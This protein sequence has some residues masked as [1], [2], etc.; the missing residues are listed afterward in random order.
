MLLP[1]GRSIK[2]TYFLNFLRKGQEFVAF[3]RRK[4]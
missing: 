1:Q 3:R 4:Q 2:S